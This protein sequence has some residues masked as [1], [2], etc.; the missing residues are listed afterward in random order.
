MGTGAY[1]A[2]N[3][4]P[5]ISVC[6]YFGKVVHNCRENLVK[7]YTIFATATVTDKHGTRAVAFGK[8][9]P[10]ILGPTVVPTVK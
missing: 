8:Y 5:T 3:H 4:I 6:P 2:V 7:R 1:N 10:A 9:T